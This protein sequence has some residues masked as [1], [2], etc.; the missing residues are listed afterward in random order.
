VRIAFDATA[1]PATLGGAG[2]Y[3]VGL[4]SGLR[5]LGTG[6]TLFVLCKPEDVDRLGP[7]D[8]AR[9]EPVPVPLRDRG[10]RLVWEQTGLPR[11]LRRAG[12]DLLHSS[13]YTMPLSAVTVARVVTFHDMIF[14]LY[15]RHHQYGKVLFFRQMIRAAARRADHIIADSDSTRLDAI[16]LLGLRDEKIATVH[17]GVDP[18]FMPVADPHVLDET[19]KRHQLH[20]PF[21]LVVST[22]EPRKNLSGAIKAFARVRQAGIDCRL[23]IAGTR[24]WNYSRVYR[25]VENRN[26]AEHVRF[27]GFVADADLPALYS[28]AEVF[29]YPSFYEGFGLPPLEAMACG[30]VVVVSN[31]SSMP[32]I[33]G[34]AGVLCNPDCPEEIGE[35]LVELLRDESA[36][37]TWRR[38]A[39]ARASRFSWDETARL[40]HDVYERVMARKTSTRSNVLMEAR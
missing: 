15:P 26:L 10:H 21:V 11:L 31:R 17:L 40:T 12:V 2:N 7:W 38:R 25:E 18:Q 8:V 20:R 3:I 29:L 37:D 6:D 33:V 16:R 23:A 14:F 35:A 22:L 13:H 9:V 5:R 4:V 28:A 32:E 36:R 27:L 1:L 39:L 24:G 30:G 19:C 34:E